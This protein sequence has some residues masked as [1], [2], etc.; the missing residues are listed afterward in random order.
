MSNIRHAP[1]RD[2]ADEAM[3][4]AL[5][6]G[7]SSGY[8][9]ERHG[10]AWGVLVWA[11]LGV[12]TVTVEALMWVVPPHQAVWI[13]AGL[14]HAVQLAGRGTLRQVYIAAPHDEALPREAGVMQV[15][16]LVRELLRRICVL[17]VMHAH[18]EAHRRLLAVLADELHPAAIGPLELPM[19]RD[20]RARR[21]ADAVRAMPADSHEI[22]ALAR[23]ASASA[24]TLERLFR[25]ETGLSFGVWRHRA[26]LLHAMTLL[27]DGASVTRTALSVGYDSTSAF[28]SA[29]RKAT[30]VTPGRYA[31][32]TERSGARP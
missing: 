16:P 24:R 17:G 11:S 21:A 10:S 1:S 3:V 20:A 5:S 23:Q 7:F 25:A 9:W 6:I 18:L 29:F 19:P 30:G 13:P 32:A 28:V 14:A 27:A 26:R 12:I 31:E 8:H 4:R 2:S 22:G 15:S